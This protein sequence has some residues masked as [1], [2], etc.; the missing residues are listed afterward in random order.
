MNL[1]ELIILAGALVAA[2]FHGRMSVKPS[3]VLVEPPKGPSELPAIVKEVK[4]E[5]KEND[6]L[7]GAER[8][9]DFLDLT[10]KH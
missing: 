6:R 2:F 1:V 10:R 3:T 8:L 9:S 4:D 5:I 7:P